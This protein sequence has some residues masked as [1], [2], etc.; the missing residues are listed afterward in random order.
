MAFNCLHEMC[1][2]NANSNCHFL[3]EP[4]LFNCEFDD[5]SEG[6]NGEGCIPTFV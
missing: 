3:V 2:P 4:V 6:L 1:L 5:H